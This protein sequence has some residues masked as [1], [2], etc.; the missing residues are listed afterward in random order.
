[1]NNNNNNLKLRFIWL[2]VVIGRSGC[3]VESTVYSQILLD[4]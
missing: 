4:V 1:M 3:T 2:I